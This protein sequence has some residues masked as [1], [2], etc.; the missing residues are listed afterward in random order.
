M[1]T[2]YF[3]YGANLNLNGMSYRCPNARRVHSL[4]L[5]DWELAFSGVATIQ[6]KKGSYV[7]GAL[8]EITDECERNL[9]SFEGYPYLYRKIELE[10]DGMKFMAYVMNDDPPR[11]PSLG[12]LM[13]IA[14]G[15]ED[16]SLPLGELWNAVKNT[17]EKY[18]D[19]QWSTKPNYANH[20]SNRDVEDLV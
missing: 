17:Q 1:K 20:T 15:Y 9:D 16:W 12:Y 7:A 8:W 18:Y 19:L 2:L 3:A 13:T 6:P 10:Q 14:E 5:E 11:E 4:F